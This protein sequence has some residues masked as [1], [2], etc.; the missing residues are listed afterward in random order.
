[1]RKGEV[2]VRSMKAANLVGH[3]RL[4]M[5]DVPRPV[6]KPGEVLIRV[7][8][9]GLCGTDVHLYLG[10]RQ[11]GYP[12][13][14]G[15]EG[16]GTIE[17]VGP[18]VTTREVGQRVIIEPNFPCGCCQFC[19][20]GDG[21]IC[22]DKRSIGV[23]ETGCF[24]EYAC[25]PARF[26]WVIPD[27]MSEDQAILV[28]PAAT[29]VHALKVSGAQPGHAIA[30]LGLGTIGLIL[31][32]LATRLGY[33]VVATDIDPGKCARARSYGATVVQDAETL[34]ASWGSRKVRYIFECAGASR[35]ASLAMANAPRGATIVLLGLSAEPAA[36]KPLDL[37]RQ[38]ISIVPSIDLRSS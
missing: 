21:N 35:T 8:K 5:R 20:R 17:A 16:L 22:P 30:V 31:T 2:L 13:I 23:N 6:P 29:A 37:V 32:Q 15:H 18:G 14:I 27:S 36:F 10:H 11:I 24:A 28:E 25:V 1:M 34:A 12:L 7:R 3:G 33:K 38:G 19:A 4:E 9:V 26:A